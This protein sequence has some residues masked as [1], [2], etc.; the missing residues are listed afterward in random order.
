[1][2]EP[3]SRSSD[4]ARPSG[5][6]EEGWSAMELVKET[7][8]L[9]GA[10]VDARIRLLGR[11]AGS[12]PRRLEAPAPRPRLENEADASTAPDLEEVWDRHGGSVYALACALLGDEAAAVRTVTLAMVD[13]AL[14]TDAD[15]HEDTLRFLARRVYRAQPGS[16]GGTIRQAP[17]APAHGVARP[18]RPAPTRMPGAVR[19]R[20]THPPRGGGPARRTAQHGGRAADGRPSRVGAPGCRRGRHQ[21]V[22]YLARS[23]VG[24]R[25]SARQRP[26]HAGHRTSAAA[27]PDVDKPRE[28]ARLAASRSDR[29]DLFRPTIRDRPR[30]TAQSSTEATRPDPRRSSPGPSGER[31]LRASRPRSGPPGT[32]RR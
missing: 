4:G 16:P 17:P 27:E 14:A 13:L 22:T 3:A 12:D 8:G 20:R 6:I 31:S 32:G 29:D 30:R 21:R 28:T 15:S 26:R 19:L 10:P 23:R 5:V 11:P 7:R 1:M 2:V 9:V 24:A 25:K 18:A